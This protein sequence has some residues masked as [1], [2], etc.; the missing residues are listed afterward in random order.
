MFNALPLSCIP[1]LLEAHLPLAVKKLWLR[2][3][4]VS[5]IISGLQVVLLHSGKATQFFEFYCPLQIHALCGVVFHT[6][7]ISLPSCFC[8][9]PMGF[10]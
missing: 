9:T 2:L 4:N 8:P 10:C 1:P 6:C 7:M 3:H 5:D